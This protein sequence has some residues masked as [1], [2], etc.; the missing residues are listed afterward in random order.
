VTES[1]DVAIVG[2]GPAGLSA[3]RVLREAGV[4][5]VVVLDREGEEGGVPRHCAHPTFGL[6][7]FRR[8][9][10]GPAYARRLRR[11]A[12]DV[13]IRTLTTVTALHP[14]GGLSV[15]TPEGPA[16]LVARRVLLAT[17]ARET[18][19]PPRLVSGTRPIGVMTTGALQQFVHLKHLRPMARAVVVGTELVSFSA[20]LTLRHAGIQVAA[21]V[22]E[23]RRV[24]AWRLAALYPRLLRV[25]IL[26]G[27]GIE[28]IQGAERV[29][30]VV[31]G[32]GERR[33]IACDGV[34]FT[35]RFVP[36]SSLLSGSHLEVTPGL[37]AP[38]VDQAWRCSDSAF[39]A[40][41]NVLRPVETA[42]WA[43]REGMSAAR[44]IADDLAG[45]GDGGGR[46]IPVTWREP[47]RIVTPQRLC[48]P[49]PRL[50][51]LHFKMRVAREA[52][53]RLRVLVDGREVVSRRMHVLPERR[54][55]LPRDL[56][57]DGAEA[58]HV[59][60]NES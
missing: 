24:V 5:R 57:L 42:G 52:R 29:E 1:F 35:G 4:Q 27:T 46:V 3:A 14:G 56:S 9:M 28:E 19:R 40:A 49:G 41:G 13:E 36:E 58:I 2:A 17:G 25:P 22:G 32:D 47:I 39:Y 53:G 60:F 11:A 15:T 18:P 43:A 44:A 7:E 20:L 54:I 51:R 45:R 16:E 23:G 50:G 6:G 30:A 12:G 37:R 26:L 33:R 21:M 8:P 48:L 59:E 55:S 10:T 38:V 31:L 34:V